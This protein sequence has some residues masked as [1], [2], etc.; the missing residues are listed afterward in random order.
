MHHARAWALRCSLENTQHA[1]SSFVTLTYNDEHLPPTLSKRH[2]QLFQKRLRRSLAT[3]RLPGGRHFSAGEY[4]ER[5]DRAHYHTI[6]FGVHPDDHEL[7][8]DAWP[9]GHID[10]Q[11]ATRRAIAYTAGY[12]AK[13]AGWRRYTTQEH[14]DPLTGE[15]Y[16]WQPPF[17]QM[18]RRPGIAAHARQWPMSWKLYAI[19]DG[20]KTKVPRYLHQSWKDTASPEQ[21]EARHEQIQ[22]HITTNRLDT[23]LSQEDA[24]YIRLATERIT[25]ARR[26][27]QSRTRKYA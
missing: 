9:H 4:G 21:Q 18:S 15:V 22:Q 20:S 10:C 27:E 7:V 13:K 25:T 8:Q 5:T 6:Q 26:S 24:D 12:V 23:P 14:V 17:L 16:L 19:H 11:P 1:A 3:R 2:L